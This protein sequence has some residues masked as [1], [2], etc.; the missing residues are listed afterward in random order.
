MKIMESREV[1]GT[2]RSDG[3]LASAARG[4]RGGALPCFSAFAILIAGGVAQAAPGLAERPA[5]DACVAPERP[6]TETALDVDV[7]A[8]QGISWPVDMR[9]APGDPSRWYVVDRSGYIAIHSAS[10]FA[11]IGTLID[12]SSRVQRVLGGREWNEMGLLGMAFHPDFA[13]NG[14]FFLYYTANGTG[15][16][17]LE[18][19]LSRFRSTNGGDTANPGTEQVVLRVNRDKQ[20]HWGGGLAFGPDGFLYLSLGDGGTHRNAQN[21]NNINGK[22]I[23]IDVDR[24]S[25]YAIPA[26]NPF[27]GGGGLPEIYA[28]GLRNPWRWSFDAE[29]GD[30]WEGDVGPSDREEVNLIV[31]GGNYGWSDFQGTLCHFSADCD[32]SAYDRPVL[33]YTHDPADE[34]SGNAV[35]GGYVYRG[36][37]MPGFYGH[38]LFGDTN[39]KLFGYNPATGGATALLADTGFTILSFAQGEDRELYAL[40]I[41]AILRLVGAGGSQSSNFPD[42]LSDSGCVA[43]G[44]PR[45]PASGLIP[46]S[47]N[48]ELWSDGAAK[49]RW[50][51]VPDGR[52]ISIDANGDF[53]YP[54]GTV[55]VKEFRL[56][57][58][59][60]ETRWM[61]RHDDG[62]WAGYT[63]EWN[64]AGTDAVLV[65]PEGKQKAIG[66]Q[67]WTYPSRSQCLEC[68]TAASGRSLGL[69]IAQLNSNHTYLSSGLTGNQ[70]ETLEF[71]GMLSAPLPDA[72]ANLDRLPRIDNAGASLEARARGYLHANCA[73]C[74]RP[75][76]PGQGPEDFRY[77]LATSQIG[78]VNEA[79]T[80]GNLG[81]PGAQLID[82]GSPDTSV[83]LLRMERLNTNVR[84]PPLATRVVDTQGTQLVRNW[85][86][87]MAPTD[88]VEVV[89]AAH[90]ATEQNLFVRATS[91]ADGAATLSAH[92]KNN[93]VL[94]AL[95]PLD[96]KS[97]TGFHQATFA[98]VA[99]APPCVAVSS[100]GGGYAELPVAGTCADGGASEVPLVDW[101]GATGGVT[102]SGNLLNYSGT[103]TEWGNN[104]ANSASMQSLGYGAPFE[105]RFTL[106]T[107][108]AGTTWVV[109]LGVNE[110]QANWRDIEYGLRSSNGRFTVYESGTWRTTGPELSAGD[111]L[112]VLVS[113][114]SVD[115]RLNGD[116]LYTSNYTGTPDFYVDTSFKQGAVAMRVTAV[117]TFPSGGDMP[118]SAWVDAAGG[119]SDAW[120]SVAYSGAPTGWASNTINSGPL[121]LFGATDDYAVAWTI[122][123]NPAGKTWI[124]GLGVTESEADWRDV[125]YGLR[126][127][128]GVLTVYENG[129]WQATAAT[130]ANGDEL[131]IAVSGTLLEYR[132]NGVPFHSRNVP[133]GREY[134][135]DTSFKEGA[136]SLENFVLQDF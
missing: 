131:A 71:I 73:M 11:R 117:P 22:M 30:L 50:M 36:A 79:P 49:N 132:L 52:R 66:N 60:I 1:A 121:S 29:T 46:Y 58:E 19:R 112:S 48:V 3:R 25:P 37:S 77:W 51:A 94:T 68:H 53:N 78:A 55:L 4:V 88:A 104:T 118:I 110:T 43:N 99:T 96:F 93:G 122:G 114:G 136:I 75:N 120:N 15:N 27:A 125:D 87:S 16:T 61:V 33:E 34:I 5:N 133:A 92:V 38:Y 59:R 126:S 98:G 41:G 129:T 62:Q 64:N 17:P 44:N 105:I 101:S 39:G 128:D 32:D 42:R 116:T 113:S 97:D 108:P 6:A 106:E 100:T 31:N 23:R 135:I 84:M 119:V 80:Q 81:V 12:I 8:S 83:M 103:P 40:S 20:W 35:I 70:L 111:V 102:V 74:H 13:T 82:P 21:R 107:D 86:E 7:V 95:G 76:G 89:T 28:L 14:E 54:N 123:N 10:N 56:G 69:E 24:G 9:Q 127:S 26:S 65:P 57:G 47:V 18:A 115:Y 109:G 90:N 134:Y 85:I 63:F 72:P 67:T 130:L 45:V 124:V 2:G 91:S